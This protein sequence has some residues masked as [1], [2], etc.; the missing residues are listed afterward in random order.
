MYNEVNKTKWVERLQCW[1]YWWAGSMN[2]DVEMASGGIHMYQ[3]SWRLVKAFKSCRRFTHTDSKMFLFF[4]EKR[5]LGKKLPHSRFTLLYDDDDDDSHHQC[6]HYPYKEC[7]L[8]GIRVAVTNQTH[9][10]HVHIKTSMTVVQLS[11]RKVDTSFDSALQVKSSQ[12]IRLMSLPSVS[13]LSRKCG[14]L[15]SHSAMGLHDLLQG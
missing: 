14:N 15:T 8:D 5:K 2:Y 7:C 9:S 6:C 12:C 13:R 3:V 4:Q 10:K 1:Y 11:W